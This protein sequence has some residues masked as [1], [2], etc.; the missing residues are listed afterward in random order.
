MFRKIVTANMLELLHSSL[1][2]H[3]WH[4]SGATLFTPAAAQVIVSL[5]RKGM[6]PRFT[7]VP[8]PTVEEKVRIIKLQNLLKI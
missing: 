6:H 3:M 4:S 5:T 2:L 7:E 1:S 8:V